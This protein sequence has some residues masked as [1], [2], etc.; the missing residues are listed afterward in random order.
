MNKIIRNATS[1]PPLSK[2]EL[3]SIHIEKYQSCTCHQYERSLGADGV[4][5]EFQRL[6][7]SRGVVRSRVAKAATP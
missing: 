7:P 5:C 3:S 4:Q 1:D 2:R 6:R